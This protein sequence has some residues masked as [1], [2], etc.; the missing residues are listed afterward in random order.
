M[1]GRLALAS[2]FLLEPDISNAPMVSKMS[3]TV[4]ENGMP[5]YGIGDFVRA[6]FRNKKKVLFVPLL[7]LSFAALVILVAPREY[8][9]E[10]KLF[11]QIGRESVKLDPTATTGDTI[12]VQSNDR[13]AEIVTVMESLKSRGTIG[14]VVERL[15]P[16]VVLGR[17]GV[18]EQQSNFLVNALRSAMGTAIGLVRSID[19]ISDRER[20]IITV[21]RGLEIEAESDS[22]LI[23]AIYEAETPELAQLVAQTL[24]DVYREEHL[25]LHSTTGSREFF[26]QQRDELQQQL[27]DAVV[28]LRDAKNRMGVVSIEARRGTLESRMGSIELSLYENIQQL[29]ATRARV[30]DIRKQLAATPERMVA[31]ETTVPNTGTDLLR[32]QV[33]ELEVLMLDQQAKYSDDHPAL[34][35]TKDQLN[36][37]RAMLEDESRDRRETT[38]DINPNHRTLSL[39]LATEESSLAGIVAQNDKLTEQRD[40]VADDLK[41]LNEFELEID[42]L[43]RQAQLA[44]TNFFRYAE[45]FEKARM[46][47]ELDDNAFSNAKVSQPATLA[48]KPVSPNKLLIAALSVLLSGFSVVSMVLVS[49]K[50]NNP[51]YKEEQLEDALQ[52]PV[53]GVVPDEKPYMSK[54]G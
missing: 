19:P 31:K 8:Q 48:E 49:E 52:L 25:R 21:E 30:A 16:E 17:S 46:D 41:K 38:N 43:N 27:D 44:R 51:I 7:I 9:S 18:G 26:T 33:F 22:T 50:L 35:A 13:D 6:L 24:I 45:K 15:G 39:A 53:F 47:E 28:A 12:S 14:K 23:T 11:M 36:Q 3:A 42:Q 32:D 4:P 37:A 34:R 1:H 29:A 5:S 20:A 40:A 10:A 2:A 54:L